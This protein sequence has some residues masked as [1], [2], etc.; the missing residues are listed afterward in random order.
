MHEHNQALSW[1]PGKTSTLLQATGPVEELM[2]YLVAVSQ[3]TLTQ[4][5]IQFSQ[6][7]DEH[8]VEFRLINHCTDLLSRKMLQCI[9]DRKTSALTYVAHVFCCCYWY[10]F[11]VVIVVVV[12]VVVVAAVTVAADLEYNF[13]LKTFLNMVSQRQKHDRYSTL[14]KQRIAQLSNTS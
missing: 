1:G 5:G 3:S 7:L 10:G 14:T 12:V 8:P 2:V 11:L 4:T 9:V 6:I 13:S